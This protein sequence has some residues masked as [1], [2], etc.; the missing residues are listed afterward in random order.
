MDEFNRGHKPFAGDYPND[1]DFGFDYDFFSDFALDEY[2]PDIYSPAP[3]E[4]LSGGEDEHFPEL[5]PSE[6]DHSDHIPASAANDELPPDPP[7]SARMLQFLD[8]SIFA[9][10]YLNATTPLVPVDASSASP[11]RSGETSAPALGA[12]RTE[13][14]FP[15]LEDMEGEPLPREKP[16]R[17]RGESAAEK[18]P[19]EKPVRDRARK[20]KKISEKQLRL[21]RGGKAAPSAEDKRKR[22]I[23]L[24]V[25]CLVLLMLFGS[26]VW[27]GFSV[28]NSEKNLPNL[29]IGG[30]FVGGMTEAETIDALEAGGW[31]QALS[32]ELLVSIAAG[33]SFTVNP[34]EAGVVLPTENAVALTKEYGHNG[35]I[36]A[37]LFT[38]LKNFLTPVDINELNRVIGEQYIAAAIEKGIAELNK[39]L[40][41]GSYT[42]DYK[43]SKLY[44]IKGAGQIEIDAAELSDLIKT[45]L[46]NG[47]SS[48][49][50]TKLLKAPT[51]PDFEKIYTTLAVEPVDAFFDEKFNVTEEVVGCAFDPAAAKVLW[52]KAEIG[53]KVT[54]PLKVSFPEITA[55]QL[56]AL[57][58]RD[59]L[60]EQ[61]T[62]YATSSANRINNL[63]KAVETINGLIIYPGESFSFNEVVGNR[64]EEAGYLPAGAYLDGNVIEEVGGGVCQVSST[65]YAA[66]LY[67]QVFEKPLERSCHYFRIPYL[68]YCMDATVSIPREGKSQDFRFINERDYPI[69]IVAECNNDERAMRIQ[70]LGTDVDGSYVV[71]RRDIYTIFHA[72]YPEVPIGLSVHQFRD[73]YAADGTYL[74][75]IEYNYNDEYYKHEEEYAEALAMAK[76][77][78]GG[79]E[80]I[81]T[82]G[83]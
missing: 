42:V 45:A 55:E 38:Y 66:L 11:R 64:T 12:R 18:S 4:H 72:E 81:P 44:L 39:T 22:T 31:E 30:I 75:T 28:T 13:K 78:A 71:I 15:A 8:D 25:A 34:L 63:N 62:T 29:Y 56:R 77:M 7:L 27:A 61:V 20:E 65:L 73:I 51:A 53:K 17:R 36:F 57:L 3:G 47:E 14:P 48:L 67:A 80:E 32:N 21:E 16:R 69:K 2:S 49:S 50:Y 19:K 58:Y 5:I 70:I 83:G 6:G 10:D 59:V 33:G 82:P 24:I 60:G 79:G 46:I 9:D 74:R 40:G 37:N 68:D 52:E 26:V 35:N 54:I 43:A 1:D 41:D 23:T 76:A